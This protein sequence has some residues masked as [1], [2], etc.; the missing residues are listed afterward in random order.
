MQKGL[1]LSI[2][3][4]PGIVWRVITAAECTCGTT[5]GKGDRRETARLI[6]VQPVQGMMQP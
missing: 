2:L 3:S 5:G 6:A 4:V 1:M